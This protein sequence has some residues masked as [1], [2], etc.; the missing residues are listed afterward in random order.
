MKYKLNGLSNVSNISTQKEIITTAID[1]MGEGYI[2]TIPE[3]E[4]AVMIAMVVV[5]END[6]KVLDDL[7]K[8]DNIQNTI[9][10]DVEPAFNEIIME[11]DNGRKIFYKL[12][13]CLRMY[14]DA[15]LKANTTVAGLLTNLAN[16][17]QTLDLDTVLKVANQIKDNLIT[18]KT[19]IEKDKEAP[20]EKTDE[21]I[22]QEMIDEI[23]NAKMKAL[24]EKYQRIEG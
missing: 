7:D 1:L 2:F 18:N 15:Q 3:M 14:Y 13:D 12:C 17:L 19:E 9:I 8:S 22:K 6:K 23:D 11:D 4:L 5:L 24:I 20:V 16:S 10:L 21:E